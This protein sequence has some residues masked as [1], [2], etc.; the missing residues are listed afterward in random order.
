MVPFEFSNFVDTVGK[1]ARELIK[2]TDDMRTETAESNRILS[3]QMNELILAPDEKYVAP[4]AQHAVPHL[5][6]APLM[7]ATVRLQETLRRWEQETRTVATS[8]FKLSPAKANQLDQILYR[9]ERALTTEEGLPRR[10]WYRHQI[11][12]PGFYT[13]Y[14]VK[15]LPG[16]REAIEE[17]NWPEA[18]Q[19]IVILAKVLGKFANELDNAAGLLYVERQLG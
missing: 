1:Y 8:G 13:G 18:E 4:K 3:E 15:T 2:L 5:N 17:R 11:Y 19:Q 6:F 10:P 14:G 7:N 12:A 16:V 9:T